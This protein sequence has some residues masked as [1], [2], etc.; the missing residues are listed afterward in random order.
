MIHQNPIPDSYY[1]PALWR[2]QEPQPKY[3]CDCC[4]KAFDAGITIQNG[5]EYFCQDCYEDH[6]YLV[7]YRDEIKLDA[8]T[9]LE[10]S[11]KVTMLP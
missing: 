4:K 3:K 5:E 2:D 11:H 8:K 9:I 7:W 6:N 10:L 1:H